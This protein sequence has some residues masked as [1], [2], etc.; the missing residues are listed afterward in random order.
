[1][2]GHEP[3]SS[4]RSQAA[5][6]GEETGLQRLLLLRHIRAKLTP[7]KAAVSLGVHRNALCTRSCG[8]KSGDHLKLEVYF[9][10]SNFKHM[11]KSLDT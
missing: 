2:P 11:K 3:C 1:M 6:Q 5:W 10:V 8:A 7:S 4:A 9:C